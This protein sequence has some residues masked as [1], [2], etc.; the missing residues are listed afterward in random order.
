LS[1]RFERLNMNSS[2]NGDVEELEEYALFSGQFKGKC[3]NCGQLG[4]KSFQYKNRLNSSHNGGNNGDT[5]V[6]I[7]CTYCRKSGHV[8]QNCF[9]LKN[10]DAQYKNNQFSNSNSSNCIREN[11]GSQD[12]IFATKNKS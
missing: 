5:T 10:K 11:Y 12:V 1:L 3:R 4:H 8:K 2:E 6:S 7:F 9:K